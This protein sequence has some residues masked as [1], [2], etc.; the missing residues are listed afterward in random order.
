[1][2]ARPRSGVR[3]LVAEAGAWLALAAAAWWLTFEFSE[4]LQTYRF[5]A[6]SWPRTLILLLAGVALCQLAAGLGWLGRR[7]AVPPPPS[8]VAGPGGGATVAT[9][10]RRAAA[11]ALP[12]AYVFLLPRAGYYATTPFFL[13]AYMALLGERRPRHLAATAL[14]I[15]AIVLLVFTRLLYVALPVG[16]WPGFYDFSHWFLSLIQ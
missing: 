7:R 10:L 12:L 8:P 9:H 1:M 5:G 4:P 3:R 16:S 13:A 2:V 6:A 11:F 15:Y 14:G